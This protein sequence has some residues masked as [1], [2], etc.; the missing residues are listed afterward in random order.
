[1]LFPEEEASS[2]GT[3]EGVAVGILNLVNLIF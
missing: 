2:T 1:M 3:T